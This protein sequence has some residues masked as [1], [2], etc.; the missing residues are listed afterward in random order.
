MLNIKS[1]IP[2]CKKKFY[3][4]LIVIKCF[5]GLI[6]VWHI[7]EKKMSLAVGVLNKRFTSICFNYIN[8]YDQK[9]VTVIRLRKM[10]QGI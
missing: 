1:A 3:L 10:V 6:H 9:N 7:K 2:I 8:N 5:Y 4:V